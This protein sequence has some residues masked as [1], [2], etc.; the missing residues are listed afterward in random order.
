[1]KFVIG[2]DQ[3]YFHFNKRRPWM[4]SVRSN[5]LKSVLGLRQQIVRSKC[6]I[7]SGGHGCKVFEVRV[8]IRI[9]AITAKCSK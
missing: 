2:L 8:Q 1:M 9:G 6:T 7:L 4:K 5:G 3:V